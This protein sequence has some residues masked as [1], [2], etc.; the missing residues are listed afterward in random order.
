MTRMTNKCKWMAGAAVSCWIAVAGGAQAEVFMADVSY[1]DVS[2]NSDEQ[3]AATLQGCL[4]TEARF[5]KLLPLLK[6][7]P[8][9]ASPNAVAATRAA[10]V[11]LA[12]VSLPLMLGVAY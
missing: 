6:Q 3:A 5:V 11:R 2:Y 10:P 8:A 7:R 9:I 4:D 1:N 12:R